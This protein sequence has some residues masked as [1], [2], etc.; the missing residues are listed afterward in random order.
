MDW[1]NPLLASL[2]DPVIYLFEF[3]VSQHLPA[4]LSSKAE[5]TI[6]LIR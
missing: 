3:N 1:E 5:Q 4:L 6:K 2:I